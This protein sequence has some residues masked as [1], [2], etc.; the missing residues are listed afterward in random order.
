MAEKVKKKRKISGR[1]MR[2]WTYAYIFLLP[3]LV[4]FFVLVLYTLINS[5]RYSL[6]QIRITPMGLFFVPHGLEN[7][8]DLLQNTFFIQNIVSF[9][10][11]S[12][13]QTPVIVSFALIIAILLNGKIVARGM[14]R[15]V[16]FLPVIIATG[17]VMNELAGIG[18]ATVP[19]V[20]TAAIAGALSFMPSMMQG[21]IVELFGQLIMILWNSGIQILIFLAA[22]QKI[23]SEQYEA[24]KIDGASGWECFW[25]ITAPAIKPMVFLNAIY[26]VV[27]LATGGQNPV[28]TQLAF[29]MHSGHYGY[30]Y[31]SAAAW[32][33]SILVLLL[34]GLCWLLLRERK[35]KLI[36]AEKRLAKR[37]W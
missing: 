4:G 20:N 34:L 17:P 25:K 7:Y 35:E 24:A 15:A 16:F 6:N 8:R 18:A 29:F 36:M 22:L 31:A 37:Y 19:A 5:F 10:I 12:V 28:I 13:L 26:T 33:Y 21:P 30:G 23:S 1:T 14:F 27:W 32:L 9:T 11:Q 3:W 2:N